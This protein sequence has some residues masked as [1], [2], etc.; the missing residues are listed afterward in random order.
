MFVYKFAFCVSIETNGIISK[1]KIFILFFTNFLE[2]DYIIETRSP[3]FARKKGIL[4]ENKQTKRRPIF[5]Y[6]KHMQNES[7]F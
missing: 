5:S 4:A 7:D 1:S 6:I 2:S 3:S